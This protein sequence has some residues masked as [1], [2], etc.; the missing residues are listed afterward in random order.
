MSKAKIVCSNSLLKSFYSLLD[1]V[2]QVRK[3]FSSQNIIIVP[4]KFS[5]NAEKLLF[6]RLQIE[7]SFNVEIMSLTRL[8]KRLCDGKLGEMELL[9]SQ[10]G[11]MLVSKILLDNYQ[12]LGLIKN[13]L[14]STLSENFYNTIL[15]LKTSGISPNEVSTKSN[16]LNLCLKL[17]DIK[18]VYSE[19][20]K[21]SKNMFDSASLLEK[22]NEIILKSN[23][24][25][26]KNIFV[27]MF[28]TFSY[29]QMQSLCKI[30]KQSKNFTIG[31]SANTVQS[32]KHIY[33]NE[34][35]QSFMQSLR[36][37]G[38]D[39]E[40][41]NIIVPISTQN[42]FLAK[43][44][45]A[46]GNVKPAICQNNYML[47]EA[48]NN[49][50]EVDYVARKIKQLRLEKNIPFDKINIA[51]TNFDSYKSIFTQVFNEYNLPYYFDYQSSLKE[52][53]LGRFLINLFYC[54]NTAF[55]E[56]YLFDVL[57]SPFL[58]K[59]ILEIEKFE[60]YYKKCGIK[61]KMVLNSFIDDEFETIR[62]SLM[63]ELTAL[64][65][66]FEQAVT[67]KDFADL[68]LSALE[69][70]DCK[71]MLGK[72]G[73]DNESDLSFQRATLQ[74]YQKLLSCLEYLKYIYDE[75]ISCE[76]FMC[77]LDSLLSCTSLSSVPLGVDK[78]Y[79]GD[80]THSSFYPNEYLFIVGAV[81]GELPKYKN[82]CGLI[83]DS[84]IEYLSSKN[85]LNP[86]IRFV[87]KTEKYKLFE[88][89]LSAEKVCISY[90]SLSFMS[91][92]KPSE[93][94]G[95]IKKLF[96]TAD[97]K[98]L[99]TLKIANEFDDAE[100]LKFKGKNYLHL[101]GSF[102]HTR[103]I[104]KS[105]KITNEYIKSAQNLT[106]SGYTKKEHI[107]DKD[108]ALP[109]FFPKK[110]TS[111]SQLERYFNCPYKHFAQYGLRL[112]ERE[113]YGIKKVDVGT[114]LHLVAEKFVV[115]YN[116]NNYSVSKKQIDK[117]I[118]ECL[119]TS[120]GKMDGK[121]DIEKFKAESLILEAQRLCDKIQ[122][123]LSVSDFKPKYVEKQVESKDDISGLKIVGKIDRVDMID[124]YFVIFDYKTGKSD[125]S[126]SSTYYGNKIQTIIY[127]SLLEKM[128]DIVPV[129]AFYIPIK[130]KFIDEQANDK[131]CGIMTDSVD[132]MKRLDNSLQTEQVKQSDIF[133]IKFTSTGLSAECSKYAL[134][135][136]E[137]LAIKNY[138]HKL[139]ANATEEILDGYIEP[140]PIK[141]ACQSCPFAVLCEYDYNVG[142]E[143]QQDKKLTKQDF[144]K[145][146]EDKN[147]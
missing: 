125:F 78:I 83:T 56:D 1:R 17:E 117:L 92:A 27:G 130:N 15:Q 50:A 109:L 137:F 87:N 62:Q 131:Y 145:I 48:E 58:K 146:M 9:N 4:D 35:L 67:V 108:I 63:Q 66:K 19:Y 127:L 129:G 136:A 68:L 107:L 84:E 79:I 6:E 115:L 76:Y 65:S 104:T 111:I 64:Y 12:K 38:V 98:G 89:I 139:V 29:V 24:F 118:D 57:K 33:L 126:Y 90:P 114:F 91:P 60:N 134:S 31:L 86:S 132:L 88:L 28:E 112:K 20:E 11:Q 59:N 113:V 105:L 18:F 69:V 147:A 141:N 47:L 39:Y 25:A 81:D 71:N 119:I 44:L 13:T 123:Q 116:N 40:I 143:R 8:V 72:M 3:D 34:T 61:N 26:D 100:L 30:A 52:H 51:C 94:F 42:E 75:Q 37:N 49:K 133:K 128:Y 41:E 85:I 77:L 55:F 102:E 121:L 106:Q 14:T 135:P 140:S 142:G 5:M 80:C 82:D 97:G 2:G 110:H 16:N 120:F 22:F 23:F 43:N 73:T 144:E 74:A 10:S 96:V 122:S 93:I 138:C 54:F 70:F 45:F 53:I 103:K 95:S 32:N 46:L 7:S 21:L 99:E 124:N 101:F 36:Q